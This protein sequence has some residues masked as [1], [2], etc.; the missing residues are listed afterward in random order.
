[1]DT[2]KS[3]SHTGAVTA[4]AIGQNGGTSNVIQNFGVATGATGGAE[5]APKHTYFTPTICL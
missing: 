4:I 3:H 2:L 5:T 1:M